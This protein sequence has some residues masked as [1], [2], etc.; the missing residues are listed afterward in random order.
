MTEQ[1]PYPR[2]VE[3]GAEKTSR[4]RGFGVR[5]DLYALETTGEQIAEI[6]LARSAG[7]SSAPAL[8]VTPHY[9]PPSRPVAPLTDNLR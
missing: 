2:D 4:K 9:G 3:R 8:G 7:R 1:L 5:N 6:L